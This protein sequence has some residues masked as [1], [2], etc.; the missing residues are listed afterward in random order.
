[1]DAPAEAKRATRL[2]RPARRAQLLE[3][4]REVFVREGYH[5]AAMDDIADA[6]GVSKPVLY[7]HFPSKQ[8]LYLALLDLGKDELVDA[9][10]LAL[11]STRDNR[12]RVEATV[13]VYFSFVND[14]AKTFRLIFESDLYNDVEV[15]SRLQSADEECAKSLMD[16]IRE[17]TNI[18]DADA[19]MLSYGLIGMAQTAARQWLRTGH[20]I[21]KEQAVSLISRMAW[22]GISGFPLNPQNPTSP[23]SEIEN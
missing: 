15:R 22:R 1:M 13:A 23:V 21:P 9:V 14:S 19:V 18:S 20:S 5:A 2:P 7:Q 4:A 10:R 3:A 12:A 8:E 17:D 11:S 16:V 6:A